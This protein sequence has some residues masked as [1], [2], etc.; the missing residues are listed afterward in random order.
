MIHAVTSDEMPIISIVAMRN[1]RVLLIKPERKCKKLKY[2]N[3][4]TIYH[5]IGQGGQQNF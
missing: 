3:L 5:K 4:F 2:K 1:P